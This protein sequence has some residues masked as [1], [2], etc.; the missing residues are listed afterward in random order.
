MILVL[1]LKKIS[2][3]LWIVLDSDNNTLVKKKVIIQ[4]C[5]CLFNQKKSYY[6]LPHL[7]LAYVFWYES[8]SIRLEAA[9]PLG[10]HRLDLVISDSCLRVLF[11][12]LSRLM[13]RGAWLIAEV[14]YCLLI[15]LPLFQIPLSIVPSEYV[16]VPCPC[17]LLFLNSPTCFPP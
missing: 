3:I 17:L 8:H 9:S 10:L 7:F 11:F 5:S 16:E 13:F 1:Y 15:N 6:T 14:C 2:D 12:N 4:H